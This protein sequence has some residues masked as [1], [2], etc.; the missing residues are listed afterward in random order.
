[1]TD[2][3]IPQIVELHGWELVSEPVTEGDA[4]RAEVVLESGE[5][6]L[7]YWWSDGELAARAAWVH[8]HAGAELFSVPQRISSGPGWVAMQRPEGVP[9]TELLEGP[10]VD[11]LLAASLGKTLRKLHNL[12]AP[13]EC[14]DVLEQLD[15]GAQARWLTFSGWVAHRLEIVSESLRGLELDEETS[16]RLAATI[17]DMRHELSAFHPRTPPS[18][19]HGGPGLAHVWVDATGR[20]VLALTGF[21]RAG[22]LPREADL[23]YLLWLEDYGTDD[24]VARALYQGYGAART[25]D[26]QRR[27]RFYRRLVA[28]EAIVGLKGSVRL[29]LERLI[30]L[31]SPR[32]V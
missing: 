3:S 28:L 12:P 18:I 24:T 29:P 16:A 30:E 25:M 10:S 23:A 26:V 27:E 1:M 8:E 32:N 5:P 17:A 21:G 19:V 9:A 20:E 13:S 7:L 14:G 11:P 15:G 2:L 6:A 4:D 31:T 22:L